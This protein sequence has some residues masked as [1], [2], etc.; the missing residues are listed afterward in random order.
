MSEKYP[1]VQSHN[2]KILSSLRILSAL[3]II[4]GS[5][6]LIFEIYFFQEFIIKIYFARIIFTIIAL[7][8]F[9]LSYKPFIIKYTTLL[10]H[11]FLISLISS[12]VITIHEIPKTIFINSQI[13]SLLVFTTAIIFSWETKNQIIV[14]IYY[15]LLFASSI[16][17]NHSD[18]YHLPNLLSLVIFVSLISFLSI[19]ASFIN[20][21]LRNNLFLISK[22]HNESINLLLKFFLQ[23]TQPKIPASQSFLISSISS[24]LKKL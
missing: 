11:I 18:I 12:F 10:T 13:L 20:Y 16:I 5:W 4:V 9:G 17:F 22:K 21:N 23:A 19:V 8:I 1:Q 2:E 7:F 14:A 24:L 6:S 15:N 3:G